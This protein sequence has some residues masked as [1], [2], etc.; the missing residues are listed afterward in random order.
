[1]LEDCTSPVVIPGIIDYTD[2]AEA[3]YAKFAAAGMNIIKSS[4]D[5]WL[6]A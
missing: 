4:T 6:D 1:L 3:A 2:R 5:L